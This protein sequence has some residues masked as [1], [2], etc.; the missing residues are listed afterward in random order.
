MKAA[1]DVELRV[2][3]EQ[4]DDRGHDRREAGDR[5]PC[6]PALAARLKRISSAAGIAT[7]QRV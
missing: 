2:G 5:R 1:P 7:P 4:E 3:E 6:V